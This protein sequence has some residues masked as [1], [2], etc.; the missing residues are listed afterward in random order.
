MKQI[1][2]PEDIINMIKLTGLITSFCKVD[3]LNKDV[4]KTA[5]TLT[6]Y[7]VSLWHV[8]QQFNTNILH[9]SA[10][11]IGELMLTKLFVDFI[12]RQYL[13]ILTP[14]DDQN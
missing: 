1:T 2:A 6:K 5:D 4:Y 14:K 9:K 8:V 7:K 13:I 12:Y 3:V 10:W 11:I